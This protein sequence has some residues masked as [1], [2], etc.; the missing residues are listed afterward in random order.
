MSRIGNP[1]HGA[2]DRRR[3]T[4]CEAEAGSAG[5]VEGK[6]E[7]ALLLL[8]CFEPQRSL[9][10]DL[11]CQSRLVR[12]P[13]TACPMSMGSAMTYAHWMMVEVME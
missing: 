8:T 2:E 13:M 12:W 11:H 9:G 4:K 1:K 6:G 3:V 10:F 5:E 7:D